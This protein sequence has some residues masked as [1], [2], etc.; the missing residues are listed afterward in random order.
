MVI[1]KVSALLEIFSEIFVKFKVSIPVIVCSWWSIGLVE[2]H[3]LLLLI[4]VKPSI[5]VPMLAAAIIDG[6]KVENSK[7]IKIKTNY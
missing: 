3:R 1:A 4:L 5:A 7:S 2:S 6:G